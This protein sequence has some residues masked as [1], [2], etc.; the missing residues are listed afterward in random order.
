MAG[1]IS[2]QILQKLFCSRVLSKQISLNQ[3][4]QQNDDQVSE[5]CVHSVRVRNEKHLS[6]ETI[7]K[8]DEFLEHDEEVWSIASC[9][10]VV[11]VIG[12]IQRGQGFLSLHNLLWQ[13]HITS[14]SPVIHPRVDVT[15]IM[16]STYVQLTIWRRISE[17]G[18]RTFSMGH[19]VCI[20]RSTWVCRSWFIRPQARID[21]FDPPILVS[22][23]FEDDFSVEEDWQN[24]SASSRYPEPSGEG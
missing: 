23:D 5:K 3:P 22:S 17:L 14:W 18:K 19:R 20:W 16:A 13:S 1:I 7:S 4:C 11:G 8:C 15:S 12:S 9:C 24:N 2:V 10:T 6:S 21:Y